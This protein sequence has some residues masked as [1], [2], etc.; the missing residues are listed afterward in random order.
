MPIRR[1]PSTVHGELFEVP[2]CDNVAT[3]Y[4]PPNLL[5]RSMCGAHLADS[6]R[7]KAS[8]A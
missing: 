5:W 3:G 7:K 1:Y 8:K 4:S 6:V 2:S